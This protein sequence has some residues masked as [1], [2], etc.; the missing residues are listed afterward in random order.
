MFGPPLSLR[1]TLI[2]LIIS[3][4]AAALPRCNSSG[5]WVGSC[6]WPNAPPSDCPLELSTSLVDVAFSGVFGAYNSSHADTWYP[7]IAADGSLF[8]SFAD[9]SVCTSSTGPPPVLPT[10]LVGL[11]W[12][13]SAEREDNVLT[14]A[15][16]PPDAS[17]AYE[18][19]GTI[20]YGERVPPGG[21]GAGPELQLWRAPSGSREYFTTSGAA[22][23]AVAR[24]AQYTLIAPL[25]AALPSSQPPA[26]P[27]PLPPTSAVNMPANV[28]DGWVPSVLLFSAQRSEYYSTP[29][30]FLPPGYVRVRQQG[31]MNVQ[32]R[33]PAGDCAEGSGV[34]GAQ[35]YAMLRGASAFNLT[36]SAVG[37]VPHPALNLSLSVPPPYGA[38]PS[39]ALRFGDLLVYGYY[40]LADPAGAG[41]SNWCHL[42]PLLGFAVA[43][44]SASGNV[45]FDVS[46]IPLWSADAAQRGVFEPLDVSAP[47]RMG[48]PRFIDAGPDMLHAPGGH[49]YLLGKG[50][51]ANDGTHCSFMTGD[52]AWLARTRVPMAALAAAGAAAAAAALNEPASWEFFAG[53]EAYS[54]TLGGAAPLF[55]WPHAVGGL[56]MTYNAPLA[57]FFVV[58]NLPGDR[59][60]P[61]DCA[62]DTYLLEADAVTGP[63]RLVSYMPRLGPQMYFQHISSA[64]WSADGLTG[65]LFSSGNWDGNCV[66]QGSN[67]PGERYGMVTTEFSL[68]LAATGHWQRA[69][70]THP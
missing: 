12:Y 65:A 63:F 41:C 15:A 38:Y 58:S 6:V 5:S 54:P 7:S 19:V 59:I 37:T 40:L 30:L 8:T 14:T 42:G 23:E 2:I 36:I 70:N 3:T 11:Q 39:T 69:Q 13:W 64:F 16:F 43:N 67:P 49:A 29:E 18:L 46:S 33:P 51:V 27:Q 50:C 25:G 17:G 28:T 47:I 45:T 4:G 32:P 26:Y 21:G 52:S 20:G 68:I 44:A 1:N 60:H 24:A 35:G 9:G 66:T 10:N 31:F 34:G 57:K 61:T 22:D 55:T 62:F 53:G 48:V 56:T